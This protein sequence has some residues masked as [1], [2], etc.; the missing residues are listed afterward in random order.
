MPSTRTMSHTF[1]DRACRAVE[2]RTK[3]DESR[4]RV[5][6]AMIEQYVELL[7]QNLPNLTDEE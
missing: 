1:S 3:A 7:M 4:S 2:Q 5:L 6:S